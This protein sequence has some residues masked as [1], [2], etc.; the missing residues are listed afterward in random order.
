MLLQ[1]VHETRCVLLDGV[2]GGV[3]AVGEL[4]GHLEGDS[5]DGGMGPVVGLVGGWFTQVLCVVHEL[6]DLLGHAQGLLQLV[7]VPVVLPGAVS[8]AAHDHEDEVEVAE[9]HARGVGALEDL[10]NQVLHAGLVEM[11]HDHGLHAAVEVDAGVGVAFQGADH[12][13]PVLGCLARADDV[14]Q[15]DLVPRDILVAVDV[16]EG[17]GDVAEGDLDGFLLELGAVRGLVDELLLLRG[18]VVGQEDSGV[19]GGEQLGELGRGGIE[20]YG[21]CAW[22]V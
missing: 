15:L 22:D 12:V 20:V 4:S 3:V 13:L 21:E 10:E 11:A 6:D 14:A 17:E 18:E 8:H 5:H 7:L 2:L 1:G 9:T 19:E 16:F